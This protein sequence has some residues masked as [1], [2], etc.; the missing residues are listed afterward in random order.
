MNI[1]VLSNAWYASIMNNQQEITDVG[2]FVEQD[3]LTGIGTV[4]G[5]TNVGSNG[6]IQFPDQCRDD[7]DG[8][9]CVEQDIKILC[10]LQFSKTNKKSVEIKLQLS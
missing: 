1:S 8:K 2:N 7:N 9:I 4:G 3:C 10:L 5:S 6:H